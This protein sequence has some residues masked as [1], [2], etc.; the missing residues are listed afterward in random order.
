MQ[1]LIGEKANPGRLT[2]LIKQK[3]KTLTLD[4]VIECVQEN[5]WADQRAGD[6]TLEV[7]AVVLG[8]SFKILL[9]DG[10]TLLPINGGG[11]RVP[12]RVTY[13]A[14]HHHATL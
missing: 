13:L 8:Q 3:D 1:G 14:E 12:A 2:A 6:I 5:D 10:K 9:P 11:A 4:K 7:S